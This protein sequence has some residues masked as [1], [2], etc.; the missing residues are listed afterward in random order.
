MSCFIILLYLLIQFLQ[1]FFFLTS[2]FFFFSLCPSF[3]P[4][5]HS[6]YSVF[7]VLSSLNICS[8]WYYLLSYFFSFFFS[9]PVYSFRPFF[10]SF[11][12]FLKEIENVE[13][14]SVAIILYASSSVIETLY[15]PLYVLAQN[16]LHFGLRVF[17]EATGLVMRAVTALVLV[18]HWQM[19][20]LGFAYAQVIFP[21]SFSYFLSQHF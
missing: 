19:G 5:V 8:V 17:V 9:P 20:L 16:H 3:F 14:Y 1:F 4:S 10:L 15:E 18:V 6:F 13:A 7:D 21:P 11:C 2:F 12:S